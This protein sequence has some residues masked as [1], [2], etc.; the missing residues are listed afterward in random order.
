M[1]CLNQL[2]INVERYVDDVVPIL[3][4]HCSIFQQSTACAEVPT[5][6][7][8]AAEDSNYSTTKTLEHLVVVVVVSA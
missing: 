6:L 8:T 2:L 1:K 4:E 7:H 3:K 5:T